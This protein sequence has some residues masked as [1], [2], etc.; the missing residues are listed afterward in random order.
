MHDEW[1]PDLVLMDVRMPGMGGLEAV[2]RL[3]Q[4]GSKAAIIAITASSLAEAES[5]ARAAGVDAFVRKPY[6]EGELLAVIGE[7]LGVRYVY[8]PTAQRSV[9][10][11]RSR[12]PSR[13][14]R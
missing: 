11:H 2:R 8:G 1:H 10:S 6:Q 3:R 13:D 5:E 7:Q 12:R 14:R 9:R 4:G